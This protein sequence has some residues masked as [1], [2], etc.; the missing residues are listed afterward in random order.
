[1]KKYAFTSQKYI[2]L[3]EIN[4]NKKKLNCKSRIKKKLSQKNFITTTIGNFYIR[5]TQFNR[6]Q[7]SLV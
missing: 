4:Y 6:F 1:M 7:T 2:S 5:H 3:K